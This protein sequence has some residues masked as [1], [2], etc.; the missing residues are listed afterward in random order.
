[1]GRINNKT[2]QANGGGRGISAE[3][4]RRHNLATVLDHLHLVG[5]ASRSQ[6]TS[7]TGLNRSTVA[8]LIG[9]LEELGLV[10]EGPR[11]IVTGPGRPS[12]VVRV[13]PDGAVVLAIEISVDSTAVATIGI[14]GHI[15]DQVRVA[16]PRGHP[17]PTDTVHQA[18]ALA[19]PLL[20]KL[21][22][23]RQLVGVGAAV[24][25]TARRDDGVVHL[26]PNLGWRDIPLAGLMTA[27]LGLGV[28]VVIANDADLCALG[29]HRRSRPNV[30]HL[31][32]VSGEVGIGC[33]VIVDGDPL[34][35]SAGYAGEAG[36]TL[37][38][39]DGRQCGCGEIGCWETEAGEAALLR[40]AGLDGPG[41]GLAALDVLVEQAVGRDQKTLA[42]ISETGRW[43]GYGIGNL[44][45]V[46]NPE[47][48][49]LGGLYHRLFPH[50]EAAAR[51]GVERALPAS[52]QV[53][54][55]APSS[56]G[57]DA[58]LIGA[59]ER[60]LLDVIADPARSLV[61]TTS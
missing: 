57:A 24:V 42:A 39:P 23:S 19:G 32:Y 31:V 12:P 16:R 61:G 1:M 27:E 44:I 2:G 22:P 45:N 11:T 54:E 17:S 25:G 33:G 5:E 20:E 52:R 14:G 7:I 55:I 28:P 37:I 3:E 50:I 38:N 60:V 29:E 41:D 47:V 35:G 30:A 40:R 56:V 18:A 4:L 36:H 21:P 43:L 9:E 46:F 53:V 59:A 6:I 8:D 10:R 58:A 51:A 26:A 15:F 49:V 13:R 34:L 48:V